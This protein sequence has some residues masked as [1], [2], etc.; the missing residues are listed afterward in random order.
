MLHGGKEINIKIKIPWMMQFVQ[1]LGTNNAQLID[2]RCTYWNIWICSKIILF[3]LN[4]FSKMANNRT[5][6]I[7]RVSDLG[8]WWFKISQF[9]LKKIISNKKNSVL[10]FEKTRDTECL[11]EYLGCMMDKNGLDITIF[12]KVVYVYFDPI[13]INFYLE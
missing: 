9:K 2:L 6:I 3:H 1:L 12:L 13:Q 11:V 7:L 10:S 4:I 8:L 5:G